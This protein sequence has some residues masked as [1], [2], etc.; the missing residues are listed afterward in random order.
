VRSKAQ[1]GWTLLEVLIAAG[2]SFLLLGLIVTFLIP[3]LRYSGRGAL[4]VELQQQVRVGLQRIL[5]D[6]QRSTASGVSLL[7]S[8]GQGGPVALGIVRLEELTAEAEQVW[9]TQVVVYCWQPDTGRLIR[10]TWPPAPPASLNPGLDP[11]KPTRLEPAELRLIAEEKNGT[12]VSVARDIA[13]FEVSHAGSGASLQPPLVL[14]LVGQAT[15]PGGTEPERFEETR[16]V[17][18]RNA[19]L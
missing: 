4:R 5:E 12:E 19:S 18:L 9:E 17:S 3:V 11:G 2:L 6:L 8:D 16:S 15:P 14:K 13:L 1:G 7:E 10:K